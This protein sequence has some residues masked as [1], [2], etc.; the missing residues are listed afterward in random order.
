M[1]HYSALIFFCFI[2]IQTNA[3]QA[4]EI[5]VFKDN[6]GHKTYTD[7][8]NIG[9]NLLYIKSYGRPTVYNNCDNVKNN[10]IKMRPIFERYAKQ[11]GFNSKLAMAVGYTESCFD[12][13]AVSK[14]GAQGVMQLMPAT[15]KELGVNNAFNAQQNIK[16]GIQYLKQMHKQFNGNI[17]YTLAAYNA[18]PGNV[19][20]YNGVPPFKETQRYIKKVLKK[21]KQYLA[22]K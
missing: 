12:S 19:K 3:T 9:A 7:N 18:G 16:A 1:H 21:Y 2:F 11:I 17:Y 4:K 8:K 15:A 6:S 13:N 10:A 20:K 14:V 5:F 22:Q